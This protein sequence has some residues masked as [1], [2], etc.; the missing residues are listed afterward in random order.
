VISQPKA[1]TK[2]K[3]KEPVVERPKKVSEAKF[4]KKSFSRAGR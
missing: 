3:S 4:H 1:Q 2:M